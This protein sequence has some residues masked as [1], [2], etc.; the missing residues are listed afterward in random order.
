MVERINTAFYFDFSQKHIPWRMFYYA[1][2]ANEF[3]LATDLQYIMLE[4]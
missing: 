4:I 1:W 3:L 2:R